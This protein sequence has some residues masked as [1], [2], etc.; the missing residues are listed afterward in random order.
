MIIFPG[1]LRQRGMPILQNPEGRGSSEK[2]LLCVCGGRGGEVWIFSG[3]TQWNLY[4]SF[5][6][7]ICNGNRT[8]WSPIRSVIIRVI[9]KS[10]DC[11]V[12]V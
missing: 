10:D 11:V 6:F 1:G 2:T 9:P 3:R 5:I 4:Q 12:G 8:E 7:L